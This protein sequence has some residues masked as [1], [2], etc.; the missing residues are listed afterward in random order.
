SRKTEI[1]LYL[2][3]TGYHWVFNHRGDH[4]DYQQVDSLHRSVKNLFCPS[5][6]HYDCHGESHVRYDC[7]G[8]SHVRY[9][10]HGE[11]H[12]RYDCHG[13]S[14][15]R[16]DCHGESHV[17]YDCHGESHVRHDCHGESHVRHDCHGETHVTVIPQC[18]SQSKKVYMHL[19]HL[20]FLGC[21]QTGHIW[22]A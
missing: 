17:R 13:E 5:R 8:D 14:P 4:T 12:V 1:N 22:F 20:S 10:C 11:S 21:I 7:H 3:S 6:V 19:C 9:D 15:V 16:Y 18:Q 2:C